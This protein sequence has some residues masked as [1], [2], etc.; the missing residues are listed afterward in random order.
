M[1][2]ML[3]LKKGIFFTSIAILISAVLALAFV[4]QASV[5][6]KDQIALTQAKA[7]SANAQARDLKFSYLP[8]SLYV[9]TYGAFYAMAE[10]LKQRGNYFL[11]ADAS[12]KF[13][14][15]LK[16][17]IIN[18]TMCC[19]LPGHAGCNSDLL[20]DVTN[21]S[22]HEGVEQC[23][24]TP[25]LAG[26]NMTKRLLD[27]ENA[28]FAA[29]RINTTF[30]KNYS[31]LKLA[32]FQDNSTGP[33]SIGANLTVGYTIVAGDVILNKTENVSATVSAL[34]EIKGIP[35]PLYLVESQKTADDGNVIH[36]NYF[37]ET[38]IT[39]WNV[40]MLYHEIEWRLYRYEANGSSFL[41]RF[42]GDD[43]MSPCCGIESLIN[44]QVMGSVN[45]RHEKPYV[46][47][48]YYGPGNRCTA[49]QAGTMWN[50]TC[51]TSETD[52]AQFYRFALDTYHAVKYN[53]SGGQK[54]YIYEAG[55]PPACPETPFP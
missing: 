38:N 41:S 26:S 39:T 16:E 44:P 40:S 43:V 18:G 28:S 4:P 27:M 46:D 19:G 11:G 20:A 42:Y 37:N 10:Y 54:E 55:P 35:D 32:I 33:W 29:F 14:L 15:T 9:A 23:I 51:I 48:C 34:I 36:A 2:L 30:D 3:R 7:D 6:T 47:W 45:G 31:K 8:Q 12:L 21:P 52:G 50:L 49:A 53:V 17:M 22:K 1:T 24:G 5:T 25:I 13:N